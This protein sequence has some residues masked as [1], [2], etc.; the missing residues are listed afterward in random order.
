[1]AGKRDTKKREVF[2][3]LYAA[4]IALFEEKGYDTVTVAE[5]TRAA[6][7]AKGTFFNHFPSKA[8]ILAEWYR[9]LIATAFETAEGENT[10]GTLTDA[11]LETCRR[12]IS[13]CEASPELWQAKTLLSPT[14]PAIQ[15]VETQNDAIAHEAFEEQVQREQLLLVA[16]ED[17]PDSFSMPPHTLQVL[18]LGRDARQAFLTGPVLCR[19][20]QELVGA[21]VRKLIKQLGTTVL[22]KVVDEPT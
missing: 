15:A 11:A 20:D 13:L 7:V 19:Q 22:V 14:T 16:S 4:A 21:H 1:M 3:A 18:S 17:A 9:R 5:I 12:T 8:D 10:A 6:G 2:E